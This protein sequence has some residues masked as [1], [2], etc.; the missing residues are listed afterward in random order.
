LNAF[1]GE[2]NYHEEINYCLYLFPRAF[3]KLVCA[4]ANGHSSAAQA[5]MTTDAMATTMQAIQAMQAISNARTKGPL[6]QSF[7]HIMA[8]SFVMRQS[9]TI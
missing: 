1:Y 5:W 3:N 8:E 4:S 7:D 6:L 9:K 2:T